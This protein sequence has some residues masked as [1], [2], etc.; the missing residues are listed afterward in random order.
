MLR[1]I[2]LKLLHNLEILF[3]VFWLLHS[4]K[5]LTFFTFE[6]LCLSYLLLL[7]YR[8]MLLSCCQVN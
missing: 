4:D 5:P 2:I 6:K 3:F 1:K 7:Q 8:I